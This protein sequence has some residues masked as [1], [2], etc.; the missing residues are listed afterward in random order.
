MNFRGHCHHYSI[1]NC[2]FQ[3]HK[4]IFLTD[5]NP[6]LVG[7]SAFPA[8]VRQ[9]SYINTHFQKKAAG[10]IF[11]SPQKQVP[12]KTSAYNPMMHGMGNPCAFS[13]FC[14]N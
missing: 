13:V 11:L 6:P 10:K 5:I 1:P 4:R 3:H 9:A 7:F 12:V 8:P 2:D 14:E